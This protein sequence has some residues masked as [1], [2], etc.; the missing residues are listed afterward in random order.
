[1]QPSRSGHRLAACSEFPN[2]NPELH[3]GAIW[4]STAVGAPPVCELPSRD[5]E[6][7]AASP[8]PLPLDDEMVEP[9]DDDDDAEPIEIVDDLA[10][11]EAAFDE[12]VD[13]M[14]LEAAPEDPF[15]KLA[16]VVKDVAV[17]FGAGADAATQL[18]VLLGLQ[19][20]EAS[21]MP[22]AAAWRGIL[23]GESEDYEACGSTT[24]DEWAASLVARVV[25]GA[26]RADG[27]R[28]ELRRR[29]VAAFGLVA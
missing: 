15:A 28:R 8:D 24:L 4:V 20:T 18:D 9:F 10:F 5:A 7:V 26:P 21:P 16:G 2:D 12:P 29:G 17:A 23:R 19:A 14:V 22:Q 25:G 1:M 11:D 27:I 6:V 3:R 13:P